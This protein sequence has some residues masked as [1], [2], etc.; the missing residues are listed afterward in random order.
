MSVTKGIGDNELIDFVP[1]DECAK[2][3]TA[4]TKLQWVRVIV[5]DYDSPFLELHTQVLNSI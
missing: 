4:G 2:S 1:S 3:I 5:Y